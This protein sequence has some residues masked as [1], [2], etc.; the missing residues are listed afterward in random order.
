VRFRGRDV[1]VEPAS[2]EALAGAELVF[3]AATGELSR[4][5]APLAVRQGA[6]VID[7][8]SSWRLDPAVPLVVPEV[9]GGALSDEARILACPNCTTI[10]VVMVLE[11]LRRLCGLA[12]VVGTTLQAASGAGREGL[13]ELERELALPPDAR[14]GE[15]HRFPHVLAGNAIPQ[16]DALEPGG[17]TREEHKLVQETRKILGLPGLELAFTCVRVPVAVGH[18]AALWVETERPVGLAEVQAALA[19]FPG[20]RLVPEGPPPTALQAAGTDQVWVGR[21]RV[22]ADGREVLLWQVADNLRKGAATNA[23]QIAERLLAPTPER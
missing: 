23:V 16:C 1:P 3:F 2:A 12:R 20:L 11:P 17:S 19:G 15:I 22:S 4:K 8:S 21:V 7:K 14:T 6:R 10:G 13:E 9:N 5:L 18:G